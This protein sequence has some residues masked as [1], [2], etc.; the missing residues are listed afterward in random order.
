M[1][2]F[3]IRTA[4]REYVELSAP[5]KT[6]YDITTHCN[7]DCEFCF[8][9]KST[10]DVSWEQA[11]NVITKIANANIPDVIFIGGEPMC[12]TF[13][14]EALEYAKSLGLNAGIVTNGTLFTEENAAKLKRLVN[15]SISISIHAPND[16]LHDKISRGTQVYSQIIEGLHILNKYN[17][18][19][20]LSFTPVKSNIAY[21][22]D[23]I[24]SVLEKGI[25]I[26]DVLVNRLIPSGNALDCWHD[27]KVGLADQKRLLEQMDKLTEKYPDLVITSGDAIPFCMVEEKYRKFITRCDYAITLGWINDKNLFGKCMVRGSSGA[28]SIE[29]QDMRYLWKRAEVFLEHRHM[30]NLLEEC[31]KCDWLIQCGG[32]CACSSIGELDKDAYLSEGPKY[33]MPPHSNNSADSDTMLLAE[34]LVEKIQLGSNYKMKHRFFIR[35]EHDCKSDTD[36]A[37]LLLP[38]SSGAVIQDVITADCG[39]ILWI[40]SVEKQTIL[41]M[42]Q[43]SSTKE[44]VK[45]IS[46][47]FNMN[48]NMAEHLVKFTIAALMSLDMVKAI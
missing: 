43:A 13:L 12:C 32:G 23:T 3:S 37:Y 47:E 18:T 14:F 34:N 25:Q 31:K 15:N 4:D 42:Q 20:E 8:K 2:K 22:Y 27:K 21:L 6:Y 1:R 40:N 35:K 24:D 38:V 26:S 45:S 41:Y 39:E 11:K 16:K 28:E 44:I 9:G 5:L 36:E 17:I 46:Y 33:V 48:M 7:L 30:K 29:N 19:P 10:T